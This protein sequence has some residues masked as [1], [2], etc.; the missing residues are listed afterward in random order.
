MVKSSK[1][2]IKIVVFD[3]YILH[4]DSIWPNNCIKMNSGNHI[5]ENHVSGKHWTETRISRNSVSGETFWKKILPMC[6]LSV[7]WH[8]SWQ[9]PHWFVNHVTSNWHWVLASEGFWYPWKLSRCRL[10]QNRKHQLFHAGCWGPN[11]PHLGHVEKRLEGLHCCSQLLPNEFL[12]EIT[13]TR[14]LYKK[15]MIWDRINQ[16][17]GQFWPKV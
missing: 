3:W 16:K 14:N 17:L 11:K 7:L 5:S 12:P 1:Q 15:C 2:L 9:G 6:Y 8:P 13:K 4:T 10:W